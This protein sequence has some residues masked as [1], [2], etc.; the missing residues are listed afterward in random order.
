MKFVANLEMPKPC[1]SSCLRPKWRGWIS[2][3]VSDVGLQSETNLVQIID[4]LNLLR[5]FLGLRKRRKQ[6]RREN[7]D[8][9][10]DDQKFNQ[11]E[12]QICSGLAT[13]KQYCISPFLSTANI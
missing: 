9:G 8:D 12:R 6:K 1:C 3:V 7:C 10:D 4:A 5:S 11:G 2:L 13:P